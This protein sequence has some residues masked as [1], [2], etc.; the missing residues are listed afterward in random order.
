M[1][2]KKT[3][4]GE[5]CEKT[6]N[7]NPR[8]ESDEEFVYI[9]IS[10]VDNTRKEIV[11][12]QNLLGRDAPS[13][14]RK[15]VSTGDVIVSTVRPNLNAIALVPPEYNQQIASTGFCVLRP[16]KSLNS[17]FLFYLVQS[18][19]FVNY[20]SR[21]AR[22]ASYPAVTDKVVKSFEFLLPP[23]EKQEELVELLDFVYNMKK[24]KYVVK[25]DTEKIIQSIFYKLFSD[26]SKYNKMNFIELFDIKTGKLDSNAS[27]DNGK[28]PFFTCSRE[29]FRINDFAFDCEALLLSGNNAAGKYSVKYYKGKFNAYQ[30][31]YVL[32]LLNNKN[33]YKFFQFQLENKLNELQKVS[34]GTNTKYLT[35]GIMKT[36][37]FIVPSP[38]DQ[39]QFEKRIDKVEHIQKYQN[40]STKK[41]HLLFNALMQKVFKKELI[42]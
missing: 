9:D 10:S 27:V 13:R 37:E 38:E 36:I 2:F 25:E 26:K 12:T 29:T 34:I 19:K 28:Y 14:A 5:E 18:K 21:N 31:T 32:Q 33:S 24:R 4:I 39:K 35:K 15:E 22:G 7:R 40:Q 42:V 23:L 41:I 20:L 3:S 8:S 30:R 1:N 17:R 6:S 11:Q 16:S